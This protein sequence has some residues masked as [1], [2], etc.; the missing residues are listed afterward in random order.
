MMM[1]MSQ[2]SGE[3]K[4]TPEI[5]IGFKPSTIYRL[6][7]EKLSRGRDSWASFSELLYEK[8]VDPFDWAKSW[9]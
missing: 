9:N 6:S 8:K 5:L 2:E 3:R 4:T 1:N 7:G